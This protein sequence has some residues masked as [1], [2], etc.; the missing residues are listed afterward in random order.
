MQGSS[1][2]SQAWERGTRQHPL[3]FDADSYKVLLRP[4]PGG[5]AESIPLF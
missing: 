1:P 5:G 4:I 2:F 3:H